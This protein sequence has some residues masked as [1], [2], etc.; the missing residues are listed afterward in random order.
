MHASSLRK[1][2][3]AFLQTIYVAGWLSSY[4]HLWKYT[5]LEFDYLAH[6]M[7]I[8]MLIIIVRHNTHILH[9]LHS[10]HKAAN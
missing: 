5:K 4:Q 8:I 2:K 7:C 1:K 6:K 10:F 3:I 9:I